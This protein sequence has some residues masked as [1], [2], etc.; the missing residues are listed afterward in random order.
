MCR[1]RR[2]PV[3]RSR[4]GHRVDLLGRVVAQHLD[5]GRIDL[6]HAAVARR[7]GTRPPCT[8]S[9]RPRNLASLLRSAS[10]ARRRS[11]AMPAICAM[12]DMRSWSRGRGMPASAPV[13]GEGAETW[14][15]EAMIGTD[16]AARRPASSA[17]SRRHSQNASRDDVRDQHLARPG[18]PPPR[19]SRSACRPA[20]DP[21]RR[22]NSRGSSAATPKLKLWPLGLE[23]TD[24]A[25]EARRHDRS[26][27]SHDRLEHPGQRRIGGD[28]LEHPALAGGDRLA[29]LAR[30][31][32][33]DAGADQPP[34]RAR[35]AHEAH[36]AGH[37]L[38]RARR[39]API[40]TPARRRRAR[41][42]CSRAARRTR[43]CRRAARA[44]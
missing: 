11:I 39:S 1:D 31:D 6:E 8:L 4:A 44:G 24:R 17:A 28:L 10:S 43:D 33:G 34:V 2:V 41:R 3:Q 37:V 36:L 12:R 13:D 19:R 29:A 27:T 32:V 35:Q 23:E 14:P 7:T 22:T 20:R 15:S 21:S 16:Q 18:T 25:H 9:N 38:A 42:R 26:I 30:G 5:E 40:R